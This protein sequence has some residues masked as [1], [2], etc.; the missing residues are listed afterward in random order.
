MTKKAPDAT[1]RLNLIFPKGLHKRVKQMALDLDTSITGLFIK[2]ATD[3]V[4]RHERG[5][6]KEVRSNDV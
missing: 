6:S 3:N 5:R 1:C 4:E 2:W